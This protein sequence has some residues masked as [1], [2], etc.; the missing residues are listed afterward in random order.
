[1][2]PKRPD[3]SGST[4]DWDSIR[5]SLRGRF[6][7]LIDQDEFGEID[8]LVQEGSVRL[9]RASRREAIDDVD[10]MIG[11]I[12]RRT[13]D[14]HLRRRYR[15]RRLWKPLEDEHLEKAP[16][17]ADPRFGDLIDRI[18]FMVTQIFEREGRDECG[19]LARGWFAGRNWK[20]LA[21]ELGLSHSSIRKRWS[22]CLEHPR[23]LFR[24]DPDF[25]D[26]FGE[27]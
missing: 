21:E 13:F 27:D 4:L 12:A 18:E 19:R 5:S 10:A 9:L 2:A 8:D 16:A 11:V 17:S 25:C 20:E 24:A 3:S 23:R 15:H 26:L 1:M 6:I 7:G 22:R 14:D